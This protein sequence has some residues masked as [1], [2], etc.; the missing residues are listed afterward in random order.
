MG[1]SGM[2]AGLGASSYI[3]LSGMRDATLRLD[4]AA[5]N[6]ANANTDNFVPDRVVAVAQASG[7]IQSRI[8]SASFD[9]PTVVSDETNDSPSLT[10]L[11]TEAVNTVT[12]KQ[13]FAANATLLK[14]Q[15]E[16]MQSVMDIV[17]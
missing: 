13:A 17:A 5:S 6:I 4:V 12:A 11:A 16:M 8:E 10:D 7:G 14:V 3:A 9:L 15:D 2:G 1:I